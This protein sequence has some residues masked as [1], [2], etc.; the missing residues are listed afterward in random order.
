MTNPLRGIRFRFKIGLVAALMA[1]AYGQ[2]CSKGKE[3]AELS[4]PLPAGLGPND[5]GM[6][7]INPLKHEIIFIT[8]KGTTKRFLPDTPSKLT[9]KKNGE[10]V[11]TI[12]NYGFQLRPYVGGMITEKPLIT[13]GLDLFYYQK[14]NFGVGAATDGNVNNSVATIHVAYNAWRSISP[15]IVLDSKKNIGLDLTLKF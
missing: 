9:L 3:V 10:V 2:G 8:P 1:F 12:P 15:G 13:V 7:L 6:A 11:I 5:V 4:A 14:Y